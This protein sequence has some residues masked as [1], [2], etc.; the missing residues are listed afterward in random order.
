MG[1]GKLGT[2]GMGGW[3]GCLFII[4]IV[5]VMVVGGYLITLLLVGD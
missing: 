2:D 4:V 3:S 1:M 5:I